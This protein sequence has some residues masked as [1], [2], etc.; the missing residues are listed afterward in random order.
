[1]DSK[2]CSRCLYF[3][4]IKRKKLMFGPFLRPKSTRIIST[5]YL[6]ITGIDNFLWY[7]KIRT[8]TTAPTNYQLIVQKVHWFSIP[9]HSTVCWFLIGTLRY[10]VKAWVFL[11][12]PVWV[13]K[14]SI[15]RVSY[16]NF[17]IK[18]CL[19][20]NLWGLGS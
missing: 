6:P 1:M 10:L 17:Y 5:M 12:L 3:R 19:K 2:V 14:K 11:V 7:I 15:F 13:Y 16:A 9:Y 4:T 8:S 20:C 18:C